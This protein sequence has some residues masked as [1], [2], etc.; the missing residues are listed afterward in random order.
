MTGHQPLAGWVASLDLWGTLLDYGDRDGE[1]A[2]RV[3]EFGRVLREFDND[4]PDDQVREVVTQVRDQHRRQQR[5]LGIQLS[6]EQQVLD[7][8]AGLGVV[9]DAALLAVLVTVHTHAVL[10]A[11]PEPIPGA[12]AAL[13][14]IKD[15]RARL[16]LTSN[17]L[18]TPAAV[19]RQ[20]IADAGLLE[21]FDDLLF[22]VDLGVAKPHPVVF[23]TVADRAGVALERIVHVGNDW[24][25]DVEG[26]LTAGCRAV[27]YNPRNKPPR[28][29]APDIAHLDQLPAA[30]AALCAA[31]PAH[32]D[33]KDFS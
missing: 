2:W 24:R 23:Q 15:A 27:F 13:A 25:T 26:A 29:Q 8:L 22:S 28:P 31:V 18:A 14:A 11:C 30:V 5:T 21:F 32:A 16:V 33:R 19:H 1:A 4:V 17:T 20:L 9:P 12:H 10:R 3:T 7:M 6:A